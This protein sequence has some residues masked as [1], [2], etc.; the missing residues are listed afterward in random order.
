LP[1]RL[2]LMVSTFSTKIQQHNDQNYYCIPGYSGTS[3][4]WLKAIEG[5]K[6]QYAVSPANNLNVFISCMQVSF[7]GTLFGI[8]TFPWDP[9]ALTATGGLWLNGIACNAQAQ[10][11][12]DAT[13]EHELGHCVGLWHTFHGSDEVPLCNAAC[14]E[15]PHNQIDPAANQ[16]GDFCA[17]TPATPRDYSCANPGGAACNGA[18]WGST[19]YTN[20]MGYG[21]EP[22]P[23][24]DHFTDQQ[25]D[26]MHCWICSA[27]PSLVTSG[28]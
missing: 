7:Q 11:S 26:R 9:I 15:L 14:E 24:G 17:D 10:A 4:A 16:V 1:L 8:A 20:Y 21:M 25:R 2:A 22:Q 19:D 28:C 3:D 27:L 13:L 5:M 12:G 6:K 23:C 18:A